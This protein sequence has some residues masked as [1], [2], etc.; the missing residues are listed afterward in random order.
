M[1]DLG[2]LSLLVPSVLG[3]ESSPTW[4][5]LANHPDFQPE[6]RFVA[7]KQMRGPVEEAPALGSQP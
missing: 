7:R 2:S 1:G 3:H 6:N 4:A 5:G